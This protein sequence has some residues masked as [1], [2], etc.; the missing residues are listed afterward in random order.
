MDGAPPESTSLRRPSDVL[1][2]NCFSRLLAVRFDKIF[3]IHLAGYLGDFGALPEERRPP[4]L[5]Y[6]REIPLYR[7]GQT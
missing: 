5:T 3:G 2:Y 4:R 7:R 6:I 1:H